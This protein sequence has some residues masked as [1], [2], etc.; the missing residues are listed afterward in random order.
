MMPDGI[1]ASLFNAS[2]PLI[3]RQ[4]IGKAFFQVEFLEVLLRYNSAELVVIEHGHFT[5]ATPTPQP[6]HKPAF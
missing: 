2:D 3:F 6:L 5:F 1:G 4:K